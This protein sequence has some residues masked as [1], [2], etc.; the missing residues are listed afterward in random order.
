MLVMAV[1]LLVLQLFTICYRETRPALFLRV[2]IM[3][4]VII[5]MITSLSLKIT[6][7]SINLEEDGGICDRRE[8]FPDGWFE[9]Y[10]KEDYQDY[11]YFKFFFECKPGSNLKYMNRAT[12][13]LTISTIWASILLATMGFEFLF[14]MAK[15]ELILRFEAANLEDQ[16]STDG[17]T[18]REMKKAAM[19]PVNAPGH[20]E[21][22]REEEATIEHA[23]YEVQ[24]DEEE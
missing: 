23:S 19:F 8:Y 21:T 13:A 12:L 6:A 14:T 5:L 22:S 11:V 16:I 20:N 24:T 9:R 15:R 17:E 18:N 2:N 3:S 1:G 7:S 10:P 4:I